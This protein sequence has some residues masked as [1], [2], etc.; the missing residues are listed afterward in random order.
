MLNSPVGSTRA[1]LGGAADQ[2]QI[3]AN[4]KRGRVERFWSQHREAS[5]NW[6]AL[7]LLLAAWNASNNDA[8][9][10]MRSRPASLRGYSYVSVRAAS[11]R[12]PQHAVVR[13]E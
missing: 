11:R 4:W 1:W 8:T 2:C 9:T 7:G 10:E 6:L 3:A 12:A 5:L 13:A